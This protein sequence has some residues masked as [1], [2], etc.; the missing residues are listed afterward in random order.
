[1]TNE[2]N[3]V[4]RRQKSKE[5]Q[6]QKTRAM[7]ERSLSDIRDTYEKSHEVMTKDFRQLENMAEE[8]KEHRHLIDK[9]RRRNTESLRN[10]PP[11]I[12]QSN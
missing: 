11:A 4:K 10:F 2:R 12:D 9:Q 6:L 8:M 5:Q 1:M 7:F 3:Q